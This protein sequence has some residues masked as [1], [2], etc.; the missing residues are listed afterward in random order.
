MLYAA[1]TGR[2]W[3]APGVSLFAMTEPSGISASAKATN[4][5][6]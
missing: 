3:L 4:L 1:L 6:S 2:A 5:E